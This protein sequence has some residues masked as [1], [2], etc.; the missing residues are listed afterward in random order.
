[1]RNDD[2]LSDDFHQKIHSVAL[3]KIV[4]IFQKKTHFTKK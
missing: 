1:M 4:I 3:Y 2:I